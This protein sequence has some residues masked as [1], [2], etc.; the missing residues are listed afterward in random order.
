MANRFLFLFPFNGRRGLG[1][2]IV[3]HTI[4]ALDFIDNAV[5]NAAQ[6]IIG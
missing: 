6:K 3:N 2:D 4:N 1:T 5:G